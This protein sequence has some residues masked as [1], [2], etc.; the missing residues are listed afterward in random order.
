MKRAIQSMCAVL[1]GIG[2]VA[3]VALLADRFAHHGLFAPIVWGAIAILLGVYVG[4]YRRA[5]RHSNSG[6]GG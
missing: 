1:F 3:S 2:L 6:R 4:L 5:Q